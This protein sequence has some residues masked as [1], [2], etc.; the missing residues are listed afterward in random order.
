MSMSKN[1]S[2]NPGQNISGLCVIDF[3]NKFPPP[4]TYQ[5]CSVVR[6]LAKRFLLASRLKFCID[7]NIDLRGKGDGKIQQQSS[8]LCPRLSE[9]EEKFL[10]REYGYFV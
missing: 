7:N 1:F 4:P 5:C 8:N 6:Y 2:D 3:D 10:K 9:N